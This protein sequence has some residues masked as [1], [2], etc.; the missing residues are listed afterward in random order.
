MKWLTYLNFELLQVI[1]WEV[2]NFWPFW[3]PFDPW[4]ALKRVKNWILS[5][6]SATIEISAWNN[7]PTQHLRIYKLFVGRWAVFEHFDPRLTPGV[8]KKGWKVKICQKW[9]LILNFLYEITFVSKFWAFTSYLLGDGHLLTIL[10]PV[11]PL[12]CLK[13]VKSYIMSKMNATIEFIIWNN[14]PTQSSRIYKLFVWRWA[15]FDHFDPFWPP[16][17]PP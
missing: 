14:I 3:P 2:D 16:F 12:G 7:I 4:D 6:M 15:L 1:C 13:R 17:W 10:T 9:M 5:K 11:L 8:V